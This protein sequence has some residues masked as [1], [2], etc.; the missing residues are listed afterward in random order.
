[1]RILIIKWEFIKKTMKLQLSQHFMQIPFSFALVDLN[2]KKMK[3]KQD[4]P[5]HKKGLL[6]R[7]DVNIERIFVKKIKAHPHTPFIA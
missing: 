1:M 7:V 4:R 6:N 3:P 5:I 2:K